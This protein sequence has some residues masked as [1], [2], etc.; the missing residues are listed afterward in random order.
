MRTKYPPPKHIANVKS[1][2]KKDGYYE[3]ETTSGL[4]ETKTILLTTGNGGFTP[5]PLEIEGANTVKNL[6]Y[7]VIDVNKYQD[8]D[9]VILGGGD[10]A[11]DYG[12]MLKGVAK[13]VSIVHRRN[14]F[15]ALEDSI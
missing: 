7:F 3:V 14:E 8:K 13:S 2:T 5:R 12:N 10:S 15:R 4:Y 11:L 9:V 1:I 6:S